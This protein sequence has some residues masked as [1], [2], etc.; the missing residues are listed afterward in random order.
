MNEVENPVLEVSAP[1]LQNLVADHVSKV[2]KRR[3]DSA[4]NFVFHDEIVTNIKEI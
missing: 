2:E 3:N 4:P 1:Q